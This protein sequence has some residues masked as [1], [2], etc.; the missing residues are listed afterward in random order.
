MNNKFSLPADI[1]EIIGYNHHAYTLTILKNSK[2]FEDWLYGNYIQLVYHSLPESRIPLDFFGYLSYKN[3]YIDFV[4]FSQTEFEESNCELIDF[5]IQKLKDEYYVYVSV[6]EFYLNC[7][8]S[9]HKQHFI[10]D[11]MLFGFDED[12]QA[13]DIIGFNGEKFSLNKVLFSEFCDSI[14]YINFAKVKKNIKFQFN[15]K[16]VFQLLCDFSQSNNTFLRNPIPPIPQ[17]PICGLKTYDKFEEMCYLYSNNGDIRVPHLLYEHKKIMCERIKYMQKNKYVASCDDIY[18]N[19]RKL[20]Q[21]F[22]KYRN[23]ILKEKI[24]GDMDKV[25]K[26]IYNINKELKSIIIS[27]KNTLDTLLD[28]IYVNNKSTL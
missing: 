20:E 12:I 2:N 17:N 6:D 11:N 1:P 26:A 14:S 18:N 28:N 15:I 5:I 4:P 9:F 27:E 3:P 16:E 10:H 8:S 25:K 21:L 7:R 23:I 19:Y 24:N 13:F 22:L